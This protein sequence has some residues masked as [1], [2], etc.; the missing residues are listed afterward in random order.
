M[1]G[2]RVVRVEKPDILAPLRRRSFVRPGATSGP[3]RPAGPAAAAGAVPPAKRAKVLAPGE[4]EEADSKKTKR[5]SPRRRGGRSADSGEGLREW[6]DKDLAERSLR[7]AAAAGGTLRRHRA[8]ISHKQAEAGPAE[9]RQI[10]IEEP[11]TVKHLSLTVGIK[12]SEIITHLMKQGLA[13]T[14]NQVIPREMAEKLVAEYGV[15]LVVHEAQTPEAELLESL[16]QRQK[17]AA[18]S[19]APVVTFMGHVDHGKTSLLDRIRNATVAAGEAGGITQ[20]FGAYRYDV[21]DQHVVFLDT[22]GHEAF[23]AMRARGANMTDVVV[24]VVAADDGVMPQTVEALSHA[25]A[26]NVPIVVALNKVDLPGANIQRAMGQLAEHGLNPRQWGGEVEV[27]E[28]SAATGQGV[29]TLL[30]TLS[31]MA[32]ILEL[33]AEETA[34]ATGFVMEAEM[35][36]RRGPLARLL[37]LNGTLKVGDIILAGMGYGRVRQMVDHVGR[38]IQ[39]AGPSTPVEISGLDEIPLAGDRFYVVRTQEEAQSVAE[40]RRQ[41]ARTASLTFTQPKTLQGILAQIQAGK[42]EE[43]PIILKA[44]VQGSA[45]ALASS[46]AKL[47]S[48]EIRV[49]VLHSAVGGITVGD[50]TLAEASKAFIVGFNVVADS[51]ARALA[52]EKGVDIRTY[53]IIYEAIEAVK[54]AMEGMLEP[55][56]KE[57]IIAQIEVRQVFKVSKVGTIAGCVVVSG[58]V[59]N[60]TKAR[61]IRDDVEIADTKITSL[62]RQKDDVREVSAGMEC[63]LSLEKFSDFKENDRVEIYEETQ[64]ARKLSL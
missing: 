49:K 26:A 24:L 14:M 37:V 32:E 11:I 34:P 17:V 15:E 43:L 51:A 52:E 1:K 36:P 59:K 64:V 39:T 28:T 41:E 2:P 5:R 23:T 4:E 48:T 30:E 45:E 56:I 40:S 20:H 55:E 61:V 57:T 12:T 54:K 29:D 58:S 47:P 50:V 38:D 8:S 10:E 62:R 3:V 53:R 31:L 60:G 9:G 7:L 18:T 42:A 44:D 21:G 35:S 6:R 19:R 63:G 27:I 25:K 33:K 16:G 13:A 22:P 46:I